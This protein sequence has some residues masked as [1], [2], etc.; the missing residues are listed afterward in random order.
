MEPE[1]YTAEPGEPTPGFDALVE[2]GLLERGECDDGSRVYRRPEG[3]TNDEWL[4]RYQATDVDALNA[5]VLARDYGIRDEPEDALPTELTEIEMCE[6]CGERPA[7]FTLHVGG[8]AVA[9]VCGQVDC[10]T[11]LVSFL[12]KYED[13]IFG[14]ELR[15]FARDHAPE[16]RP[17]ALAMLHSDHEQKRVAGFLALL[18]FDTGRN[19]G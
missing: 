16:L 13:D 11:S 10:R 1:V 18:D 3:M 17:V 8:V 6:K 12:V 5:A 4:D 7:A 14:E 9:G 19:L 2:G 15:R